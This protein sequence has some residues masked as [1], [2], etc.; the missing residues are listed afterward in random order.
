MG[1]QS[2]WG[3]RQLQPCNWWEK[4]GGGP[5]D[6]DFSRDSSPLRRKSRARGRASPSFVLLPASSLSA[7]Q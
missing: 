2:G 5:L 3:R 1:N 4:P 7:A 6:S